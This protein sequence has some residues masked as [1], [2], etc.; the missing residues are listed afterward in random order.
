VR[1]G[2][3]RIVCKFH[4]TVRRVIARRSLQAQHHRKGR[5]RNPGR[6]SGCQHPAAPSPLGCLGWHD[7]RICSGR[8]VLHGGLNGRFRAWRDVAIRF[9]R[10][11]SDKARWRGALVDCAVRG[12]G[13]WAGGLARCDNGRHHVADFLDRQVIPAGPVRCTGCGP[14][15][16]SKKARNH[17]AQRP[18]I[19]GKPSLDGLSMAPS[20]S[21]PCPVCHHSARGDRHSPISL[22]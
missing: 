5:N 14:F 15:R 19:T 22:G 1:P 17:I 20:N 16:I 9:G 11:C 10:G 2:A 6:G 7:G 21:L 8:G 18:V 4:G 3:G 12:V 13:R